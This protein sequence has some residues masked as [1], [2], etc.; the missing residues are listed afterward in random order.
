MRRPLAFQVANDREVASFGRIRFV[1]ILLAG[2]P[3]EGW[4]LVGGPGGRTSL[5]RASGIELLEA[6]C[7]EVVLLDENCGGRAVDRG[8]GVG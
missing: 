5:M 8:V 7:T 3:Q 2:V 4:S 1:S 6:F